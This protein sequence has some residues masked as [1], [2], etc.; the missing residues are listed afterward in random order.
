M[1]FKAINGLAPAYMYLRNL[2]YIRG[3]VKNLVISKVNTT[4]YRLIAIRYTAAKAWISIPG[5]MR[6]MTSVKAF[7]EAVRQLSFSTSQVR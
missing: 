6:R 7:R 1:I 4:S 5:T 2:F 3:N